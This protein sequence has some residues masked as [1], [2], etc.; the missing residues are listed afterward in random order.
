MREAK[1][2][3][4]GPEPAAPSGIGISRAQWAKQ[5]DGDRNCKGAL[6]RL[7]RFP[8]RNRQ[9]E[10]RESQGAPQSATMRVPRTEI[11]QAGLGGSPTHPIPSEKNVVSEQETQSP[12]I[13]TDSICNH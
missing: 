12:A 7:L 2:G 5:R 1:K 4:E 3:S 11:P 8:G 9:A 10:R 6:A 13:E